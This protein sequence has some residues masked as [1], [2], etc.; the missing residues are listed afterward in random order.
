MIIG[1]DGELVLIR[2]VNKNSHKVEERKTIIMSK[3]Q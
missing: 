1:D 2:C 3:Q